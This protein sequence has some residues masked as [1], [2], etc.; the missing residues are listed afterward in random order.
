MRT[1]GSAGT[2][3]SDAVLTPINCS[4]VR[5]ALN[6]A[7]SGGFDFLD[8]LV[9]PNSCDNIRRMYDHWT[10]RTNTPFIQMASLPRK[11]GPDQVAWFREELE[12][13]KGRVEQHFRVK[14]TPDRLREAISL[15][16]ETRRLLRSL[17]ALRQNPAPPITGA[18]TLAVTVAVTALPK[19]ETN[20]RL[21]QLL[22]DL[23]GAEGIRDGRA[24]L[25]VM[26][27]ELDDPGFLKIIE[28]LGGLVVADSLCFGSRMFWKEVAEGEDDPLLSLARFYV[29]ERPSCP[30]VYGQYEKRAGFVREMIR[31]FRVDGVILERLSF[32]DLWGFEK[33][34]IEND[35]RE[36]G[37]P[38]LSLDREYRLS[39]VGQLRTR[40][41]AFLETIGD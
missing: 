30:R 34:T 33:F 18:E 37:I 9:V 23:R 27:G 35:F 2:E 1:P 4:F 16:N 21:S 5:H 29:A 17:Y 10:R 39:G 31:E 36:W 7:L 28:D 19:E 40:V 25:M 22:E 13:L 24:R 15:H 8:G 41:Q 32:C 6:T 26:G 3:L 14:I 12:L 20:R 38:L 11:A